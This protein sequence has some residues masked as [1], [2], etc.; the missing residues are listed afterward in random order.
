MRVK[1][2][3]DVKQTKN[4]IR[5]DAQDYILCCKNFS[6]Y[7]NMI[8]RKNIAALFTAYKEIVAKRNIN[9]YELSEK[10]T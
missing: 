4:S 8:N 10:I 2:R 5:L 7:E 3:A 6:S 1:D 9:N